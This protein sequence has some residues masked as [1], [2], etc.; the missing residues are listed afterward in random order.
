MSGTKN[1]RGLPFFSKLMFYGM[2]GF[3]LEIVFTAIWYFVD[4]A[5]NHGWKLHGSTSLWS[6]PIYGISIYV[7]ERIS[8]AIKPHVFLPIRAVIYIMWTYLWEYSTGYIL[9]KFNACPWDYKDYTTYHLHGLITFDYAPLWLIAVVLCEKVT[10]NIAQNLTYNTTE[11][12]KS[13]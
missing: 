6:F 2:N 4:P 12:S 5:Y 1:E 10:I 9:Q 13:E 8:E 7:L 3:F 11:K